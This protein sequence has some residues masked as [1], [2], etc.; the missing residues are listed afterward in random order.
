MGLRV[1]LLSGE[2]G[3]SWNVAADLVLPLEL[4]GSSSSSDPPG[5]RESVTPDRR[6]FLEQ[7]LPIGSYSFFAGNAKRNAL[8][9]S[10]SGRI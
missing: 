2:T 6:F 3:E 4:C 1:G 9:K 5:R 7:R 10:A 8:T